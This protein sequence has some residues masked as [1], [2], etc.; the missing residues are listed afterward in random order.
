VLPAITY[1]TKPA[2][3]HEALLHLAT[4]NWVRVI[5]DPADNTERKQTS[6][7]GVM[8]E[9]R[10]IRAFAAYCHACGMRCRARRIDD[11]HWAVMAEQP[12]PV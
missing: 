2:W 1:P 11:T 3:D 10:A 8:R 6:G 5:V 12:Q 7:Y 9:N 4:H